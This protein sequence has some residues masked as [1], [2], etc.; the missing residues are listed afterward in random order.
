MEKECVFKPCLLYKKIYLS[1]KYDILIYEST[2]VAEKEG[3]DIYLTDGYEEYLRR[4]NYIEADYN[5]Y[6]I[7]ENEEELAYC[8][9]KVLNNI[10]VPALLNKDEKKLIEFSNEA[11]FFNYL[12]KDK[13]IEKNI[14]KD[15][16][17]TD[18]RKFLSVPDDSKNK[19][20]IE[21]KLVQ[22]SFSLIEIEEDILAH[23]VGQDEQVTEIATAAY[24]HFENMLQTQ[25]LIIGPSGVGKTYI[26][27]QVA[28]LFD[29]PFTVEDASS[30]TVSGYH[31]NSIEDML[32]HLYSNA[33]G[34]LE[35]AQKGILFIDEIDKLCSTDGENSITKTDVLL[36]LLTVLQGGQI[37]ITDPYENSFGV[38][39]SKIAFDT[40]DL[41]IICGG[42]FTELR[43]K[44]EVSVGFNSANSV[45]KSRHS[46]ISRDALKSYGMPDEFMGRIQLIVELSELTKEN[47]LEIL[48]NPF[49]NPVEKYIEILKNY[50]INLVIDPLV[51]EKIAQD[52]A[53]H[54]K[55]ARAI[56]S[57]MLKLFLPILNFIAKNNDK[58]INEI[59]VKDV[60]DDKLTFEINKGAVT[61][62]R[63]NEKMLS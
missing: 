21:T 31:G 63:K 48:K 41:L 23:T 9:K 60:F 1:P 51:Y 28:N 36:S 45:K 15:F 26:V 44:D 17:L 16:S 33:D 10:G 19:I 55:G 4:D 37:F 30:Y 50:G 24:F 20:Q 18:K 54:K 3:E 14:K 61:R 49:I 22:N 32:K 2:I 11:E 29:V 34:D 62:K 52:A 6:K 39:D 38:S 43:E 53:T 59:L 7:F 47:L 5:I 27:E 46:K 40:K 57:V 58:E 42:A 25:M 13:S 35:K 8:L 56:Q 12:A